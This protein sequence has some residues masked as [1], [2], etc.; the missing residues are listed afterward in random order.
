M[1]ITLLY[2]AVLG[3]AMLVSAPLYA[4]ND[5]TQAFEKQ[6]ISVIKGDDGS[7]T[8]KDKAA[9]ETCYVK[10]N[11]KSQHESSTLTI[12]FS[13][14]DCSVGC[15]VF[16]QKLGE[17]SVGNRNDNGSD[18]SKKFR[19]CTRNSSGYIV[20]C[21]I[22]VNHLKNFCYAT[23]DQPDSDACSVSYVIMVAGKE[24]DPIIVI[25][26]LPTEPE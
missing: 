25:K 23:P 14:I 24:V 13:A 18:D 20:D 2:G 26:P 19:K 5:C 11:Q 7:Y 22:R 12:D 21:Q 16:I 10:N 4:N 6:K 17:T 3:L 1:K 15:K 8:V 9:N